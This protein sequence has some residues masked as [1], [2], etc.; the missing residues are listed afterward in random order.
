MPGPFEHSGIATFDE[1][2]RQSLGGGMGKENEWD[3][4][5]TNHV[6]VDPVEDTPMK[7]VDLGG[8]VVLTK[9]EVGK[10]GYLAVCLDAEGNRFGLW[11]S[12][13]YPPKR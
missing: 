10:F 13:N 1:Q 11:E 3:T 7:L 8:K 9:T 12:R 2:G 5:I 4:G 6:D